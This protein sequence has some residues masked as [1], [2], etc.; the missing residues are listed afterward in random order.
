VRASHRRNARRAGVFPNLIAH[1]QETPLM[2][3]IDTSYTKEMLILSLDMAHRDVAAFYA[4]MPPQIF[5]AR[6]LGGWSPSDNLDHLLKSVKPVV[7]A[8]K[9]PKATLRQMFGAAANG[10]RR[11]SEIR[12]M[13]LNQLKQ[14]A[15]ATGRYLPAQADPAAEEREPAKARLLEQWA[16]LGGALTENLNQWSESELDEHVLPHPVLGNLTFREMLCFIAYHD[17]RHI[18]PEGD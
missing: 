16:A 2:N 15:Q 3:D 18:S 4:A 6:P 14:G 7:K 8:L 17:L 9:L 11:F 13:Y 10:S 5:F 1:A 12:D